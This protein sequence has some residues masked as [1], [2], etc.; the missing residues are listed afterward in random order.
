MHISPT[1]RYGRHCRPNKT[2]YG[3]GSQP[4]LPL[5]MI[6]W[7]RHGPISSEISTR[8]TAWSGPSSASVSAKSTS[9]ISTGVKAGFSVSSGW[10]RPSLRSAWI[11]LVPTPKTAW[12]PTEHSYQ[13]PGFPLLAYVRNHPCI[14]NHVHPVA[15][16]STKPSYRTSHIASLAQWSQ[17]KS[18]QNRGGSLYAF[19]LPSVHERDFEN[20]IM[21]PWSNLRDFIAV[22]FRHFAR[23][24]SADSAVVGLSIF[25]SLSGEWGFGRPTRFCDCLVAPFTVASFRFKLT[26][27]NK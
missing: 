11:R 27:K 1:G 9:E 22:F 13:R 25:I 16:S 15:C 10:N 19:V 21:S 7:K 6:W 23:H 17:I 12:Q 26:G 3:H 4:V 2:E 8:K 20:S 24:S 5:H 18:G 14:W